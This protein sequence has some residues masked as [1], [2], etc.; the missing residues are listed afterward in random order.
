[1]LKRDMIKRIAG[2]ELNALLHSGILPKQLF[3]NGKVQ[4]SGTPVYDTNGELLLYRVP[5]KKGRQVFQA[6]IAA[7]P[8]LGHPL[9]AIQLGPDWSFPKL[10]K[11][12]KQIAER[13]HRV[14]FNQT[15]F[16]AYSYP[17]LAIQFLQRGREVLMLELFTWEKVPDEKPRTPGVPPGHFE[18]WSLLRE[19]PSAKRVKNKKSFKERIDFWDK[20]HPVGDRMFNPEYLRL[21][22]FTRI[23]TPA[24]LVVSLFISRELHYST[25]ND[26][27]HPCYELRGQLTNVW[28]VA[29]SVQMILDFY[30]YNYTQDRLAQELGLGTR[31]NPNGLPYSRANDVV[32]VL[33]DLTSQALTGNRNTN[34]N[35]NEFV[36]EI[37]ANRPLI[38]WIPGH[39]RTVAGYT[40]SRLGTWYTFRGLLVYDPWPPTGGSIARWENFD[41]TTYWDTFTAA[42]TLV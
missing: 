18:R 28:C 11:E 35:W 16:V 22:D 42:L 40:R 36:S 5:V 37:N 25:N 7:N 29:A 14:K 34:A 31:A 13:K 10:L 4:S 19:I 38:S 27:H 41:L 30:R 1:M 39:S 3:E 15:R 17:K 32:T 33:Q 8:E 9:M 6:D 2:L 20:K 23:L 24:E 26:D 21:A 12:G